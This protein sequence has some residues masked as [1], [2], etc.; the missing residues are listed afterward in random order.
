MSG[1]MQNRALA[2][3]ALVARN[4]D[5]MDRREERYD[6]GGRDRAPRVLGMEV[7]QRVLDSRGGDVAVR[8][9][10]VRPAVGQE[11]HLR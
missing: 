7:M 1:G 2:G 8:G 3:G 5:Y 11:D 9:R 4:G 6:L 10:P